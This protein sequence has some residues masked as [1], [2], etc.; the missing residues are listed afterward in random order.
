MK[1]P[2]NAKERNL[3]KGAIRRV[4]SRSD[5]RK[6][7]IN[8]SRIEWYDPA[9]PRVTKWSRCSDCQQATATYQMEVDH[10]VPL[11]PLGKKLE[12]MS[13]DEVVNRI[14]CDI[15][16]LQPVCKPCHKAKS[17]VE[18]AERRRLAKGRT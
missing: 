11:V 17:K 9:R 16:N 7:V 12:E 13:W 5:L 3:I 6:E 14:W 1:K 4:F 8:N 2:E 18:N 15:V 10:I